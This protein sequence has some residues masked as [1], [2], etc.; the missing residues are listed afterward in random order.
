[1]EVLSGLAWLTY[2]SDPGCSSLG[3]GSISRSSSRRWWRM[4]ELVYRVGEREDG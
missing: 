3:N 1:M 2:L 4:N